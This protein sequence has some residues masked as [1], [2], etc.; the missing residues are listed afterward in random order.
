MS[1]PA[2]FVGTVRHRRLTPVPH[3]FTYRLFMAFLDVD[4]I[5]E[6][7]RVSRLT[8]Y[9]AWNWASF[10]ERDHL[11][12]PALPLRE[13]VAAE[14]A[15]AGVDWPGGPVFLLTNLRYLGYCFNPVSFFYLFD[16]AGRLAAVLAEVHNTFG[17]AHNY[18]LRPAGGSPLFRSVADK[19]LYVSPFLPPDLEYRF[20]LTAP[21]ERLTVHVDARRS[22]ERLFD[23]TLALERRPWTAREIRRQLV[24][25]PAMTASVIAA[26]HRQALALWWRGVP[27]VRRLTA[28]GVGERAAWRDLH[29]GA[30]LAP[31]KES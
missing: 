30:A 26:I 12:D 23:A 9:N 19:S 14:A 15:R 29:G 24:R 8:G 31:P 5:P 4:R 18:W 21:A 16:R 1:A 17:G 11:G 13:R 2:L 7:M 22:G 3:R 25:Q 10:D 20:A 27:V 28:D 6:L